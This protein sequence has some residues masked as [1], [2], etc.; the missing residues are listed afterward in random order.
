MGRVTGFE[1]ATS[2]ATNWRSNQLSYTRRLPIKA[3][4]T[5]VEA[6]RAGKPVL[7]MISCEKSTV[8]TGK[9]EKLWNITPAGDIF[10]SRPHIER[11]L[12][13]PIVAAGQA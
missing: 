7:L 5:L 8:T 2:S 1:P 3:R 6:L 10:H 11:F 9:I 12:A 13:M 4:G